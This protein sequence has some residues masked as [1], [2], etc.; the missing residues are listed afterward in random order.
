[1]PRSSTHG[2]SACVGKAPALPRRHEHVRR[3]V[4]PCAVRPPALQLHQFPMDI[5][6]HVMPAP[7]REAADRRSVLLLPGGAG[8]TATRNENGSRPSQEGP[9]PK[10]GAEGTRT[11]DPHTARAA[12]GGQGSSLKYVPAG[13]D[14]DQPSRDSAEPPCTTRLGHHR[15]TTWRPRDRVCPEGEQRGRGLLLAADGHTAEAVTVLDEALRAA[16]PDGLRRPFRDA[17]PTVR[18]SCNA[19]G[20]RSAPR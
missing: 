6:S 5:Y 9:G 14:A 12:G 4:R 15:G 19:P 13:Q 17:T 20:G 11:P 10:G 3:G 8:P 2:A 7:A 1:M 16:E 18:T